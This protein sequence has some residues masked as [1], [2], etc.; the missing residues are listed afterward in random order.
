MKNEMTPETS[1]IP[2]NTSVV[3]PDFCDANW[4]EQIREEDRLMEQQLAEC[5]RRANSLPLWD[6]A[7]HLTAEG[8]ED[9]K[10]NG[11][12]G[13]VSAVMSCAISYKDHIRFEEKFECHLQKKEIR[14]VYKSIHS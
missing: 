4:K 5:R 10:I 1:A 2:V 8:Y 6:I 14:V 13:A 9:V 3:T 11:E 7:L 12:E